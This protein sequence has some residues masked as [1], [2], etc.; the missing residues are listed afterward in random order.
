MV[1]K[2]Y[3]LSKIEIVK[4][5]RSTIHYFQYS[6]ST[7]EVFC[8]IFLT[9]DIKKEY[10]IP[11]FLILLSLRNLRGAIYLNI[12]LDHLIVLVSFIYRGTLLSNIGRGLLCL[13]VATGLDTHMFNLILIKANVSWAKQIVNYS[14]DILLVNYFFVSL[15]FLRTFTMYIFHTLRKKKFQRKKKQ[16]FF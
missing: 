16:R 14:I 2:Y 9:N 6:N 15:Y 8:K 5:F 7:Q 1:V 13:P 10:S 4:L 3:I 11:N 12:I